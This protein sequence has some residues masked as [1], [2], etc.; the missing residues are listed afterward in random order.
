VKFFVYLFACVFVAL[1]AQP[2]DA[3]SVS[4]QSKQSELACIA[5]AIF[6]EARGESKKGQVFVALVVRE[7]AEDAQGRWPKSYCGVVW[8]KSPQGCQ[9]SWVCDGDRPRYRPNQQIQQIAKEVVAGKHSFP[10]GWS[11]VRY[12]ATRPTSF[13]K[14]VG[15]V[16]GHVF[17]C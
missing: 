3:R 2:A 6:Y 7:R 16:G 12:F 17:G 11:C 15:R 13:M 14:E 5:Q 4:S 1:G 10:S 9:F 8:Q